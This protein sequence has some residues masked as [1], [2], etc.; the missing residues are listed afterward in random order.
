MPPKP[1]VCS[2]DK[3]SSTIYGY[4]HWKISYH[5][6]LC[7]MYLISYQTQTKHLIQH[8]SPVIIHSIPLGQNV[9]CNPERSKYWTDYTLGLSFDTA[10]HE[11]L[12]YWKDKLAMLTPHAYAGCGLLFTTAILLA[13]I[14][15]WHISPTLAVVWS[16]VSPMPWIC[17][18][19]AHKH[20][21]PLFS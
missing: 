3:L 14:W 9:S 13:V 5:H 2:A 17:Y 4:V 12:I 6:I 15:M 1:P 18:L 20:W 16:L 8:F 7:Q 19:T 10:S 21:L 11:L